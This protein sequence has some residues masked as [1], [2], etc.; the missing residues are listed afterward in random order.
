MPSY[1]LDRCT[2]ADGDAISR[3]N[4]SA[5]WQ[6]ANWVLSWRHTT[7]DKHI[8]ETAK[9]YPRNLLQ[10]RDTA[11]HQ[12]AVDPETGRLVGYARWSIPAAHAVTATGNPVWPD[13]VVPA[14]SPEEEDEFKRVAES[15]DWKPDVTSDPLD[16]EMIRIK[17][18]LI[19]AKPYMV[20]DYLAVHPEN[21]RRGIATVLIESG[22]RE[23]EKLGLDIFLVARPAGMPVYRRAGFKTIQVLVQDDS[24]YGGPGEICT[25]YMTYEPQLQPEG[26]RGDL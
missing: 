11:R 25:Y 16:D 19:A 3:N 12:K 21:Q 15:A 4:M 23:A 26:S 14:V 9:R 10:N 22:I 17:Q 18:E 8:I 24:I 6:D 13:A 1:V 5:F 7:L 20:L 2:V